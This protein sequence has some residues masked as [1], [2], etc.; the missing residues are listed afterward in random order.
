MSHFNPKK[1]AII[2]TDV[3]DFTISAILSQR[4]KQ[5]KLHPVVYFSKKLTPQELSFN[6]PVKELYAIM[7]VPTKWRH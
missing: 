4:N 5:N 1:L 3:S 7:C 2:E 6:M